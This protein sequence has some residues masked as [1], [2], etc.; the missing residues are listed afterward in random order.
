MFDSADGF[1]AG[2][3]QDSIEEAQCLAE[4]GLEA[5]SARQ[6]ALF[7]AGDTGCV[8]TAKRINHFIKSLQI[9]VNL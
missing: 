7:N 3:I 8:C 9:L 6:L 4:S 2:H 1:R 5:A